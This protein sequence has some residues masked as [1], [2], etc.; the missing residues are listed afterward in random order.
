[1]EELYLKYGVGGVCVMLSLHLLFRVGEFV[2]RLK[3]QSQSVSE[4]A[5]HTLTRAL[6]DNTHA[7]KN[8]D[9]RLE[10]IEKTMAEFPKFKTDIR[11]FYAA[12]KHV[13]GDAWPLIRDEIMKDEFTL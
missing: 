9:Q 6:A 7:M 4:K 11:R 13:A 10:L 2:W 12:I 3:E 5:V 1:M 8:L